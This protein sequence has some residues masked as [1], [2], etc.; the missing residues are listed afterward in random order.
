MRKVVDLISIIVGATLGIFALSVLTYPFFRYKRTVS[1]PENYTETN[2]VI[3]LD[4]L[5]Q[6]IKTLQLEYQLNRITEPDFTKQ[7][8][9]YR[10]QAANLLR[11]KSLTSTYIAEFNDSTESKTDLLEQEI[12]LARSL[13]SDQTAEL[14]T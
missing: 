2:F 6:A 14:N 13:I 4:T 9:N 10:L 8:N 12:M 3:D 1:N 7:L 5:Y 11:T